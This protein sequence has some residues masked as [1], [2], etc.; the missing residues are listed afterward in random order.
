MD[1]PVLLLGSPFLD[2]EAQVLFVDLPRNERHQLVELRNPLDFRINT[3]KPKQEPVDGPT[4]EEELFLQYVE[5]VLALVAAHCH[6]GQV[7]V[8]VLREYIVLRVVHLV[9][10]STV[11]VVHE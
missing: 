1:R 6:D 9:F 10:I 4:I 8:D 11:V 7:V 5:E 2:E 3:L